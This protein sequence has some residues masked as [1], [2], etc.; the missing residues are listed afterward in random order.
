MARDSAS[1]RSASGLPAWGGGREM[2]AQHTVEHRDH[3]FALRG[4]AFVFDAPP[5]EHRIEPG[6]GQSGHAADAPIHQSGDA[7]GARRC[8]TAETQIG[9]RDRG[10][11]RLH[12]IGHARRR[13]DAEARD[14]VQVGQ[15]QRAGIDHAIRVPEDG[16][17]CSMHEPSDDPGKLASLL[18]ERLKARQ[19]PRA[20]SSGFGTAGAGSFQN[21]QAI[22]LS[23]STEPSRTMTT[24]QRREKPMPS[25]WCRLIRGWG[26]D[27]APVE[28]I[29]AG[30]DQRLEFAVAV[31]HAPDADENRAGSN[32]STRSAAHPRRMRRRRAKAMA[33]RQATG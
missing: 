29:A 17:A 20:E 19:V 4:G 10:M 11:H 9:A 33:V 3:R 27:A 32:A 25:P 12:Q 26:C 31:H 22:C 6:T 5:G 30:H 21:T 14:A 24:P 23:A 2:I 8:R 16:I 13:I 15:P 7:V 18:Q 1:L 28:M